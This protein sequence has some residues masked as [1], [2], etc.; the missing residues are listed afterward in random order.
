MHF[1][2]W[3]PSPRYDLKSF[4]FEWGGKGKDRCF[5]LWPH[6]FSNPVPALVSVPDPQNVEKEGLVNGPGVV[7]FWI[8]FQLSLCAIRNCACTQ[9]VKVY[10]WMRFPREKPSWADFFPKRSTLITNLQT[11]GMYPFHTHES[12]NTCHKNVFSCQRTLSVWLS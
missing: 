12:Y 10:L 11:A 6:P 9:R 5:L 4:S 8:H 7:F 2:I 3:L 1:A